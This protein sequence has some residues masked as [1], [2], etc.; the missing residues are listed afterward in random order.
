[1]KKLE[2]PCSIKFMASTKEA[3]DKTCQKEDRSLSYVVERAVRKD[4]GL[5]G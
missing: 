5:K 2:K 1:M 4:L 3:L